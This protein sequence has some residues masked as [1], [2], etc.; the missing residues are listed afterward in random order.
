[1][2]FSDQNKISNKSHEA[3]QRPTA[4]RWFLLDYTLAQ[5]SFNT[6]L[7]I[8]IIVTNAFIIAN[9]VYFKKKKKNCGCSVRL[10]KNSVGDIFILFWNICNDVALQNDTY[11]DLFYMKTLKKQL[12]TRSHYWIYLQQTTIKVKKFF[13]NHFLIHLLIC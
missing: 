3:R 7:A 9:K 4:G 11:K 12:L 1:M 5:H 8:C 13:V 10:M 6:A 2:A